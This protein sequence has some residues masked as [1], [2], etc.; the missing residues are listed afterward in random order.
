M[1][2][3]LWVEMACRRN[4]SLRGGEHQASTLPDVLAHALTAVTAAL[5]P[6]A[7]LPTRQR[8]VCLSSAIPPDAA[9]SFS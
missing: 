3:L 2:S 6:A 9:P 4:S 8:A 7:P 1:C 5:R